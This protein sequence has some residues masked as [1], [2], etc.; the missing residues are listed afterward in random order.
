VDQ[1]GN[2]WV[3]NYGSNNVTKLSSAGA[4]LGTYSGGT[5]PIG[6]A[7]DQSGNVWVA[8]AS[9]NNVT[10]LSSAGATLGTYSVGSGPQYDVAVDQSGNVWVANYGSNNVT[11][12]SSGSN[13]VLV[14]LVQNLPQASGVKPDGAVIHA[15]WVGA[16][17]LSSQAFGLFINDSST[18]ISV[19]SGCTNS[20]ANAM[21][22]ATASTILTILN[23]STAFGSCSSVGTI[24][25][26][27]S[28]TSG[29]F[30]CSSGFTVGSDYGLYIKGPAT[31]DATLG[32]IAIALYGTH[33]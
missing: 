25:F 26:A 20:T 13:G 19:P 14:P 29:T 3:A 9:S 27:A 24:A 23:C 8:N 2:V 31:A 28:G 16:P 32:N 4:T 33:N 17:L 15:S 6:V 7:V 22:A 21:T 5:N 12:L 11:K 10:K 30:T 18:S 1:S